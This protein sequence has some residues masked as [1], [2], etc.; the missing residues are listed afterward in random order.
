M[1]LQKG[2]AVRLLITP[3]QLSVWAV[4]PNDTMETVRSR[5]QVW[6]AE[7]HLERRVWAA[8]QMP[9]SRNLRQPLCLSFVRLLF[10]LLV[11]PSKTS[12]FCLVSAQWAGCSASFLLV[13]VPTDEFLQCWGLKIS[14]SVGSFYP[15]PKNQLINLVLSK[16]PLIESFR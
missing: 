11:H 7:Q 9:E 8:E 5:L 6:L 2:S 13:C 12:T 4:A 10:L 14:G 3:V 1:W 15:N 16:D